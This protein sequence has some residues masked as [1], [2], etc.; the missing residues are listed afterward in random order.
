MDSERKVSGDLILN[1]RYYEQKYPAEGDLVMVE[2]LNVIESGA[3]VALL[4]YDNIEGMI[5]PNEFSKVGNLKTA[6]KAIRT[7]RQEIVKVIKVDKEKGYIDLS[8]K[9]VSNDEAT[10]KFEEKFEKAK[11]VHSILR[12]VAEKCGINIEDLYEEIAWPLY[13]THH[14]ALDAFKISIEYFSFLFLFL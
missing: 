7:G 14:H 9:S 2:V 8:K 5:T 1:S 10:T 4:E 6:L 11:K 13:K 3:Y 12:N